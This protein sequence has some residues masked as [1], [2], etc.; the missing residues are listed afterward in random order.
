M[1]STSVSGMGSVS[2]SSS[3]KL[4]MGRLNRMHPSSQKPSDKES[5]HH[6]S[7]GSQ[8][9]PPSPLTKQNHSQ[10]QQQLSALAGL[11]DPMRMEALERQVVQSTI[12]RQGGGQRRKIALESDSDED[13]ESFD[14]ED[15]EVLFNK[16]C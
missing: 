8:Q 16:F 4:V 12:N 10:P 14:D 7:R 9:L 5:S 15:E 3:S 13:D 6:A 1:G 2:T 11:P